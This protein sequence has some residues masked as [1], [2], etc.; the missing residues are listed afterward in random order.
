M[1]RL[2][3]VLFAA[4]VL[5]AGLSMQGKTGFSGTY[6]VSGTNPG[7]GAYKGTLTIT[8]RGD[9]YDVHWWIAKEQYTG[10][11]IVVNDTL[12]VA[13]TG[14]DRSWIGVAAYRQRA[15]GSLDGRWAVQGGAS[16]PGT[17]IATRK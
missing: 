6:S 5:F 16:V 12:S 15:D 8:P 4:T 11:G 10:V 9:V 2:V 14:G 1:R 13:Y 3:I 17:E 7:V